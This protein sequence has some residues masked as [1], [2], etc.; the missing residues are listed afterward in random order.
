M[1]EICVNLSIYNHLL[2]LVE[3]YAGPC[4]VDQ[5]HFSF[6]NT[7]RRTVKKL[8]WA[9]CCTYFTD[10]LNAWQTSPTGL[11]HSF[12]NWVIWL[13]IF[14]DVVTSWLSPVLNQWIHWL[15]SLGFIG[16]ST[17]DFRLQPRPRGC[18]WS[19]REQ[20]RSRTYVGLS[21]VETSVSRKDLYINKCCISV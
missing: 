15:N 13:I 16:P 12:W 14:S 21:C 20:Q 10:R 1:N 4:Q 11:L 17:F 8:K 6:R 19:L 7:S 3:I 2:F 18:R 5:T 9:H